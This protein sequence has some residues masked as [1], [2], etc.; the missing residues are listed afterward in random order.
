MPVLDRATNGFLSPCAPLALPLAMASPLTRAL[1]SFA[2]S[3]K[4]VHGAISVRKTYGPC[5]ESVPVIFTAMSHQGTPF[6]SDQV[7][8]ASDSMSFDFRATIYLSAVVSIHGRMTVLLAGDSPYYRGE[9]FLLSG[10]GPGMRAPFIDRDLGFE[11]TSSVHRWVSMFQSSGAELTYLDS[12]F[13]VSVSLLG[14]ISTMST[15]VMS[16]S[17]QIASRLTFPILF[18]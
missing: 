11:L 6:A 1:L 12:V 9:V 3:F 13:Q 18:Q 8:F 5:S 15:N 17:T 14:S 16:A 7:P 10:F 4:V 2:C